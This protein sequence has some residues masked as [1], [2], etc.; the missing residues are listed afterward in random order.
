[1]KP[2]KGNR[3]AILDQKL[4]NNVI[5]DIISDTSKLEKLMKTQP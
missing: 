1:M 5:K 2:N 4:Y 3:V